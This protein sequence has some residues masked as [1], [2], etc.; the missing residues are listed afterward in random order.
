MPL[1]VFFLGLLIPDGG[2]PAVDMRPPLRAAD[3][4]NDFGTKTPNPS[5]REPDLEMNFPIGEMRLRVRFLHTVD[6]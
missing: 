2:L 1:P 5:G 3:Y 4:R 6:E